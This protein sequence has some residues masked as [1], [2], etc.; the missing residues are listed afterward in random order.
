[1]TLWDGYEDVAF[2]VVRNDDDQYSIWP[3]TR[4]LP[5]GWHRVSGP[6]TREECLA[7]I[8]AR[9]TDMRP[10]G[11]APSV[12]PGAGL[13][14]PVEPRPS[15]PV[16]VL[17]E[18]AAGRS[19][20]EVVMRCADTTLDRGTLLKVSAGWAGVLAAAGCGPEVPVAVLV[21]RGVDALVAIFSVLRAGGAYVPL[22]WE[23]SPER[24]RAVLEDCGRPLVLAADD[25][26]DRL[27]AYQGPVLRLTELRERAAAAGPHEPLGTAVSPDSLAYIMYTSG[28]TGQPKGVQ[29]THR[30]LTNYALWCRTAFPH[31]PGE[32]TVLQ[33]PLA[34]LG[35]L[36]NIFTP[37]LAGWPIEILPEGATIDDLLKLVERVPVGLLKLTPTHLRMI[38]ARGVS[39]RHIARQFM[40]GSEPLVV[41]DEFAGWVKEHPSAIYVNHYGLTET[42]GCFCHWFSTDVA[43]GAG[44]PVGLPIDNVRAYL[45]DR[46]GDEVPPGECGELL[47]AGESIARGYHHK[48]GLTAQR[49]IP[50]QW[51]DNGGRV[52]RTGDLARRRPDGYVEVLGRADRQVKVRGH[53]VEP[54]A[55]E[56]ALRSLPEVLEALV[57]PYADDGVTTLVAYLIPRPGADLDPATVH[58]ALSGLLPPPAVPSRMAVLGDFPTNANGKVDVSALPEPAPIQPRHDGGTATDGWTRYERI[59]AEVYSGSLGVD[60]VGRHDSFFDL[61]GDSLMAVQVALEVGRKLGTD[62]PVPTVDRGTPHAYGQV[63]EQMM[64]TEWPI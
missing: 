51:S 24:L 53:R 17:I 29:G 36:T 52:L 63:L 26:V 10:A 2:D 58:R 22:S 46:H 4:A 30:Q 43:I 41:T 60:G 23:D 3:A 9:W 50:D 8:E 42:H 32:W 12:P 21:P 35:S 19:D 38:L 64:E 62:V 25:A 13:C 49:W 61:G 40:I 44:V 57:L 39:A 28:T 18:R 20:T 55:V 11:S 27:P 48:P 34:F 5:G 59:V 15:V 7:G 31:R 1:V 45:V 14:G 37:L 16:H 6:G 56:H 47:V 33:A 54:S